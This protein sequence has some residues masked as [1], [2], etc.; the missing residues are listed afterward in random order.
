MLKTPRPAHFFLLADSL[1]NLV[2]RSDADMTFET[3]DCPFG[4]TQRGMP[5]FSRT[6]DSKVTGGV[7][8]T[9]LNPIRLGLNQIG[10][11]FEHLKHLDQVLA[12][13]NKEGR[14][15]LAS[16]RISV[17]TLLSS[18]TDKAPVPRIGFRFRYFSILN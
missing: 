14:P 15:S 8:E 7:I 17:F 4:F 1:I 3:I 13:F 2:S 12:C 10:S 16:Y 11:L 18:T 9:G 6:L 5:K